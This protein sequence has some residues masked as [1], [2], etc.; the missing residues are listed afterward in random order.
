MSLIFL[1][2]RSNTFFLIACFYCLCMK[3]EDTDCEG[4]NVC[5]FLD[6]ESG[7]VPGCDGTPTSEW[8]YCADPKVIEQ[9]VSQMA[10]VETQSQTTGG[11]F[12]RCSAGKSQ[13]RAAVS[14]RNGQLGGTQ[15]N[16]NS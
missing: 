12:A 1:F 5:Y 3:D 6:D 13:N 4:D 8:E 2:I 7:V 9:Y 10:M 16:R 14:H 15:I 11:K